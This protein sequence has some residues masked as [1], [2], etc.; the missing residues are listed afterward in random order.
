VPKPPAPPP[1]GLRRYLPSLLWLLFLTS[2][3]WVSHLLWRLQPWKTERITLVDYTVPFEN[4]REHRGGNWLLNH[5]KYAPPFGR[6]WERLGTYSGYD[7]QN[8]PNPIRI[9]SLDLSQTDWLYV[10]DAYGVYE[11]D[12][13]G[14]DR[15]MAHMDY[16]VPLFGGL[17]D[18][19][20][21][22]IEAYVARGKHLYL[23][24]NSLEEPTTG[25]AR[26]TL[27]RLLG[28]TWTGW[29]GRAFLNL[30]DTT[31][32]PHWLPR[33]HRAQYG[34]TPMPR[35]PTLALVNQGGRLVLFPDRSL[36]KIAPR[37][38]VT[39]RGAQV[40]PRA[41]S[42]AGYFYWFPI[43][44]ADDSTE[45]LAEYTMLPER[46]DQHRRL[47]SLGIARRIP[48]LTRRTEGGAHR[49]YM[50]GD[51]S[52]TDFPPGW[53]RFRGLARYRA[54]GERDPLRYDSRGAYWQ[55]FVP[56]MRQLL[57]APFDSTA[58]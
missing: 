11:D 10:S 49:I 32:V 1:K 44:V 17:S 12:L 58:N 47:D 39:A 29:T 40:I 36:Y 50:M 46:P 14:I 37:V 31:D 51:L 20:A 18:G 21:R 42:G 41:R 34:S 52:D 38:T 5:E 26:A 27:E 22:A 3:I 6:R 33:L 35:E 16:S 25:A 8:R 13:L 28:I 56:A 19:D 23:E 43:Y 30:Y 55:F 48:L 4:A 24:F 53:F 54:W 7:P 45:V 15:Q 9:D 57:R 2:P